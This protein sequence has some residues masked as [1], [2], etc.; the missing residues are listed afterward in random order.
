MSSPSKSAVIAAAAQTIEPLERRTMLAVGVPVTVEVNGAQTFQ[1]MQG[2][3]ASMAAWTRIPEYN[4]PAF[5]DRIVNDLGATTVRAGIYPWAE[6]KNDDND[7]N[8]F[9]W[10]GFDANSL[11]GPF[12]FFKQMKLRG[13]NNFLISAW[14]AP[15]WMK[16]NNLH[17]DGGSLRA[18]MYAEYAEYLSA[19]VQI[20]K[21][22]YG[23]DIAAVSPQNEPYFVEPYESTTYN[24]NQLRETVRAIGRKFAHDGLT[25]K[26]VLP[27]DLI[28]EDRNKWYASR[29]MDDPETKNYVGAFAGHGLVAHWN[30]IRDA[31]APYGKEFWMTETSGTSGT[32]WE[33]A[34]GLANAIVNAI[35]T[36]NA[37]RFDYW[38]FDGVAADANRVL[39]VNG[40]PTPKYYAAK[41]YYRWI[42]PGMVHLGTT[43]SLEDQV[44]VT[45]F[46]DPNSGAMT[47]VIL[48]RDGDSHDVTFN[49][50]GITGLPGTYNVYRSTSTENAISLGTITGGSSFTINAPGMSVITITN[51]PDP[52]PKTGGAISAGAVFKGIG[53][54][55]NGNNFLLAAEKGYNDSLTAQIAGGA[56]VNQVYKGWTALQTASMSI[57]P[58]SMNTVP[59]LINAGANVN[60]TNPEGMTPLHLAAAN[61]FLKFGSVATLQSDKINALINAGANVN[62]KDSNGRTPLIWAAMQGAIRGLS[63]DTGIVQTLLNRGADPSVKDNGGKTALDWANE[64]GYS[65]I[66]AAIIAATGPDT[67][68]PTG[69]V[70]DVSPDPRTTAVTDLFFNFSER[71]NNFDITDIAL[72]R[73]GNVIS[74]AGGGVGLSSPD[75]I[76]YQLTG[77]GGLTAAAG[78][79]L[80]TVKV[81]GSGITDL[82]NNALAADFSDSWTV[83]NAPPPGQTPFKGSPFAISKSGTTTIELEDFDNGGEGVAYHDIDAKNNGG[84]YRPAE[85]VDVQATT[86]A[87]G[88]F[89]VGYTKAGEWLEYS[90]NVT[91]AGSY[92]LSFR[93][94]TTGNNAKFH[95]EIDGADVTGALT[96][97]NTGGFQT[98][99]TLTKTGV[100]LTA[101]AH[102]L[103]VALDTVGSNSSV[104]NFNWL[105]IAP[106]GSP[107]PD[108]Q[109]PFKG[110]PFAVG[111]SAVRIEAEDFDNGGEGIAYHDLDG[112]NNGGAYRT[113]GVDVQATTDAGGGFNVGYAKTGEWLEY[114]INVATAGSYDLGFRVAST[115]NN[116]KF[117]VAIDGIDAT[118]LI[119]VPNTGGFQNWQTVTKTAVH[120]PAG[121]HVLRLALDIAGTTGSVGNFN[122]LSI[123]PAGSV[124]QPTTITSTTSAYVR[125]GTSAS[126]NFGSAGTLIVK[127]HTDPSSTREAFIR[128]NISSLSTINSAKLRLFGALNDTSSSSV[129]TQVFAGTTAAWDENT[130]TYNNSRALATGGPLATATVTGTTQQWYELDVTAFLK[131]E[132]ALGHTTVTLV[133]KNPTQ[134]NA[135]VV[136]NSDDAGSNQPQLAVS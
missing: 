43:S 129:Q 42:R 86:D 113:T 14:T 107:P 68:K 101:G 79:Y 83:G 13:V 106:T 119:T 53:N 49:L 117:H 33:G 36:A 44:R 5:F 134:Q 30:E 38:Q 120:L 31:L 64:E 93:V 8:H 121:Q 123:A 72:T 50:S 125:G 52:T 116:G 105:K 109:S 6:T 46:R 130:L 84:A 61:T 82:A 48:N 132:K 74:L 90:I 25:T 18:D 7:P 28:F 96:V 94:A 95:A 4:D 128:F 26:I 1:T 97:P 12:E 54:F 69:D 45:T 67:T 10:A 118:G 131:S 127:K 133:L 102:I 19:M 62:A 108:Q 85:G 22:N 21:N 17:T 103:R 23:V 57:N 122:W 88:G 2:M 56:D 59:T 80:V 39:L 34:I 77:L 104:G 99:Q 58:G 37:S 76:H 66:A 124:N 27:E 16:T 55:L 111:A 112:A 20:A 75:Q 60:S 32:T 40:Q 51:V 9:N 3:G 98:W 126:Q 63:E 65:Q 115:G 114:T 29:V 100:N 47:T 136:F 15:A 87:G 71:V 70:V 89:N 11:A 78:N 110:T 41:Q 35:G 92:D 135:L 91:D 24:A 73:D 81:A